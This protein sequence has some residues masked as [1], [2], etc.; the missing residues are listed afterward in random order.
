MKI[1]QPLKRI[2]S[3]VFWL[4]L[5][6]LSACSPSDETNIAREV[7]LQ[8]STMGSTYNI[9]LIV[10]GD[11]IDTQA[12]HAEIDKRL[13]QINQSLSTYIPSS[14]LSRFNS[15]HSSEPVEI[16]EEF[17]FV[18]A[19]AL[20]LGELTGGKLD[21]TIGALVNLWG[22]G[23]QYRPE[24]VPSAQAIAQ[25]RARVGLAKIK[26]DGHKLS[27]SVAKLYI[28]LS[29]IAKGYAVDQVGDLILKQGIGNYMVEIG[30]EMR[31]KGFKHDGT[32]WHVAIE[33]PVIGRRAIQ[34]II[35]LGDNAL[36]SA[37]DYRNY[38]EVDGTR[39]SHIIDPDTAKPIQ[40]KLVS[41]TVI[42]PLSMTADGLSTGMMLMGPEQA[43][44]FA[45]QHKLAAFFI[46]KT[47]DGFQQQNTLE[48]TQFLK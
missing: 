29:T 11:A 12:V 44:I 41:V 4:A 7:L 13:K 32:L 18:L 42:H 39:Y 36:A 38:F 25:A 21:V 6:C 48:F 23:P 5:L 20:R 26:L 19:E 10:K 14:E 16:S 2:S 30:G 17:R 46:T 24:T 40:H 35:V 27:K 47:Q 43:L 22:F 15:H 8:G 9:K 45:T 34:Q 3:G 28:D 37:G 1:F 33:K 31:T